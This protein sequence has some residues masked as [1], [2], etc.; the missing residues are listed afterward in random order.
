[1]I[2]MYLEIIEWHPF[3]FLLRFYEVKFKYSTCMEIIISNIYIYIYIL[4]IYHCLFLSLPSY[5]NWEVP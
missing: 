5:Q 2:I 4:Y 1:M 3:V